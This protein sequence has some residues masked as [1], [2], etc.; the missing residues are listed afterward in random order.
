VADRA[1]TEVI[2]NG[3]FDTAPTETAQNT[4]YCVKNDV[5]GDLSEGKVYRITVVMDSSYTGVAYIQT[6][7]VDAP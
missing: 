1:G 6:G 5:S 3:D 7:R 4:W 2:A